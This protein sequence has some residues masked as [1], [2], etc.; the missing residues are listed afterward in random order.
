[1]VEPDMISVKMDQDVK[2]AEPWD[3]EVQWTGD[4]LKEFKADV[5]IF[6]E[7]S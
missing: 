4:S 5:K 7:R 2:G 6:G 1:M 3:N